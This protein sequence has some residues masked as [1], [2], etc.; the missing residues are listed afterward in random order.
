MSERVCTFCEGGGLGP[1]GERACEACG[2]SGNWA[3]AAYAILQD[4]RPILT[5]SDNPYHDAAA[6]VDL[7]A[8]LPPRQVGT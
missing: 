8:L 1:D 5:A 3:D 4:A 7:V 6:V 2:G